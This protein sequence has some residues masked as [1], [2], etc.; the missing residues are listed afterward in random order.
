MFAARTH[1]TCPEMTNYAKHLSPEDNGS[2]CKKA[3]VVEWQSIRSVTAVRLALIDSAQ[4]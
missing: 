3:P 2:V 4:S 1:V